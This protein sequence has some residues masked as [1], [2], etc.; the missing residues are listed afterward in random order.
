MAD[1][2]LS[3]KEILSEIQEIKQELEALN[4]HKLV[5]IYNSMGRLIFYFFLRGVVVGFG[6]VIGATVVVSLFIY[7]LSFLVSQIEFI[8]IIG[9]W[10]KAILEEIQINPQ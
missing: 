1:R 5:K 6:T 10:V 3:Q 8:P 2:D 7:L 4:S 9:E